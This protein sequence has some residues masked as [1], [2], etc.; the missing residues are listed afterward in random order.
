VQ[1]ISIL[2]AG[3]AGSSAALA[4][5]NAGSNVLLLEKSKFPRH[6]VCGEFFSPEI[7]S[8]LNHLQLWPEFLAAAP[9]CIRRI[10]LHFARRTRESRLHDPA[11]GLSRHAFDALLLNAAL[12]RGAQ[13]ARESPEPP[14]I[15]TS[16]RSVASTTRGRRLFGFKAHFEG[17]ASDA[18]ELFFFGPCYVGVSPIENGRTNVCGI[19]PENF[20]R[21][22]GFDFDRVLRESPALAARIAPL[23]RVID[24]LT[25]GPLQ[26]EQNFAADSYLAGDALSFVDPFTGSGLVAAVK[27]GALAGQAA[28][29][30]TPTADY[31]KQCRKSLEKPFQFAAVFRAALRW[32]VAESLAPL[33]PSQFLF[34]WT[35]PR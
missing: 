9:A 33:V 2:G 27:T 10:K 34:A 24:W 14:L 17:P 11:W 26:F 16:G 13:L 20:L 7:E 23:T 32:G 29:G 18:V 15:V 28:A 5:L 3:P 25:T 31:L 19:A 35:R 1:K 30:A 21:R 6:K 22:F 4:A 8:E 12:S